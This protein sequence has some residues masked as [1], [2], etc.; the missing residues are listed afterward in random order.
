MIILVDRLVS[1]SVEDEMLSRRGSRRGSKASVI[2]S[3]EFSR[4]ISVVSSD[5]GVRARSASIFTLDPTEEVEDHKALKKDDLNRLKRGILL[6][7]LFI[8]P[9]PE[10]KEANVSKTN[11]FEILVHARTSWWAISIGLG[12]CLGLTVGAAS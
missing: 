3:R 4:E 1:A 9:I 5:V 7:E 11:L 2:Y 8:G 10:L 6:A 12:A